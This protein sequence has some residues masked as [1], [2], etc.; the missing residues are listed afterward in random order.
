MTFFY[1][2]LISVLNLIWLGLVPLGLPG[3]WLM[4]I[5]AGLVSWWFTDNTMFAMGTLI[6]ATGLV[7]LG[8]ILETLIMAK[9]ASKAGSSKRGTIGAIIGAILGGILLTGLVPIPVLG[10]IL[11]VCLGAF[12]GAV[13][14]EITGGK[15][16]G[17]SFK[18]GRGAAVGRFYGTI[19]KLAIGL[20][21]WF[22]LS[23]GAFF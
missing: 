23:M 17:R 5:T 18:V 4:V 3:N 2:L 21:V 13:I 10:T 14:M 19:Y 7:I 15:Q 9:R 1:A 12:L 8:E 6:V 20:C 22:I 11:G 16:F